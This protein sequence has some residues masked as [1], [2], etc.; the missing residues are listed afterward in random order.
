M[1]VVDSEKS[2]AAA[3]IAY[4]CYAVVCGCLSSSVHHRSFTATN[5][6]LA[7]SRKHLSRKIRAR[8]LSLNS[9]DNLS[10]IWAENRIDSPA[11]AQ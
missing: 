1:D 11:T 7:K 8:L 2:K 4:D 9:E 10:I 5:R 6:F 3:M